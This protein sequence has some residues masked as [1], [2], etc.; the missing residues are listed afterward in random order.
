MQQTL[1]RQLV[2]SIQVV[3]FQWVL[4]TKVFLRDQLVQE[5]LY[6]YVNTL[7]NSCEGQKFLGAGLGVGVIEALLSVAE[8]FHDRLGV[9][10]RLV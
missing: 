4:T 9:N 6:L 5:Y 1:Q 2:P 7:G 10:P 3:G 8:R